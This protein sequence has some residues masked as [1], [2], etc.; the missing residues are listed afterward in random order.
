MH[1]NTPLGEVLPRHARTPLADALND[2][3]VVLLNGA[4]QCGKSTLAAAMANE[5][6]LAWWSLDRQATL[7]AAQGDPTAFVREAPAM[8]IDE[9]QRAP[10]LLLAIKEV[11]DMDP[12]PG[13]FLLTGSSHVMSLRAVPDALP[14]RMETI[15]LFPLSQ[16]EIEAT[17]D[18]F[19][20]AA[21]ARGPELRAGKPETRAS[22]VHRIVRGGFPEALAREGPRRKRFHRSYVADLIDRE[23]TQV[24]DVERTPQMRALVRILASRSGTVLFANQLASRLELA[25]GTVQRYLALLEEVFLIKRIPAWTGGVAGRAIHAPKLAFVD[26][27][28][29]ASAL[30]LDQVGLEP[31]GAPLGGLLEAFAAMEVRRQLTWADTTAE[32]FHYRSRDKIEVDLV[33][34][35]DRGRI[36]GMEVKSSASLTGRE[37]SGLRHLEARLGER[38]L[39]G[40]VLYLGDQVLPFGGK[41]RALPLNAIWLASAS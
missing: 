17:P 41:M 24:A 4:R 12:A 16:G 22:Y 31:I 10:E 19:V 20:D 11:V 5:K 13:H 34:E 1:I 28:I 30:G 8:V 27:G 9:V 2:T 40:Y 6:G 7:T 37:F 3:R 29:A 38:F 18:G 26:S 15:E 25:H 36:I 14:G 21:F 33:L 35:D 32:L 23:V 39:A